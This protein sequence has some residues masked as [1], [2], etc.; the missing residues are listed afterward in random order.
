MEDF[1]TPNLSIA[2]STLFLSSLGSV[3]DDMVLDDVPIETVTEID[4]PAD[5]GDIPRANLESVEHFLGEQGT[6]SDIV[7]SSVIS[8]EQLVRLQE[9]SG[10]A[11]RMFL[12]ANSLSK[13][14]FY[15]LALAIEFETAPN[16]RLFWEPSALHAVPTF[17]NAFYEGLI[18]RFVPNQTAAIVKV[19]S[20]PRVTRRLFR[21]KKRA[22]AINSLLP[23]LLCLVPWH[24]NRGLLSVAKSGLLNVF[25][26]MG[27]RPTDVV[28]T[29]VLRTIPG[30]LAVSPFMYWPRV[31]LVALLQLITFAAIIVVAGVLQ[32]MTRFVRVTMLLLVF[33]LTF[34][35]QKMALDHWVSMLASK[36][37]TADQI[38]CYIHGTCCF[39]LPGYP[40]VGCLLAL[41]M[42]DPVFWR[43]SLSTWAV[44]GSVFQVVASLSAGVIATGIVRRI[45]YKSLRT[46]TTE[47]Q[48]PESA[49]Q[50]PL[51][52]QHIWPYDLGASIRQVEYKVARFR[53]E[54]QSQVGSNVLFTQNSQRSKLFRAANPSLPL[55]I[56]H[57]L[58]VEAGTST[59]ALIRRLSLHVMP[60]ESLVIVGPQLSGKTTLIKAICN[61]IVKSGE[62]VVGPT[63]DVGIAYANLS[64][65]EVG[66]ELQRLFFMDNGQELARW[67]LRPHAYTRLTDLPRHL[68]KRVSLALAF[69]SQLVILDE[70]SQDADEEDLLLLR[71]RLLL[72]GHQAAIITTANPS[73]ASMLGTT[74][75]FFGRG[76][77]KLWVPATSLAQVES[78]WRLEVCL[79]RQPGALAALVSGTNLHLVDRA[80]VGDKIWVRL[81]GTGDVT[82]I[83]K[84]FLTRSGVLSVRM[85]P[86]GIDSVMS[87]LHRS[88]SI[89]RQ[90]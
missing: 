35:A 44:L 26:L 31:T 64:Y 62:N 36:F 45:P 67:G 76:E 70:P 3:L 8:D 68:L 52:V 80:I 69:Q 11:V 40:V 13:K 25:L 4:D 38:S 19:S 51:E 33:S 54:V 50:L 90:Q 74:V 41:H 1:R 20:A 12:L 47:D 22:M 17:V 9:P 16:Y 58:S 60:G 6:E 77:L 21:I 89:D 15:P 71:R 30:A 28:L 85:L 82:E 88:I 53:E 43:L 63:G 55:L 37:L 24:Q 34:A 2:K 5:E 48:Y 14:V 27:V 39:L 86:F 59:E 46:W 65:L 7:L 81:T 84:R 87:E 10:V 61:E 79:R 49:F 29:G 66:L 57:K 32:W 42:D 72:L 56:V 73:V 78:C 18:R 23:T 75:G 83:H